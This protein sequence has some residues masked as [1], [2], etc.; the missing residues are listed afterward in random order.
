MIDNDDL[1]P[2]AE[3]ARRLA[4]TPHTVY[5]WIAA[6]RLPAIRFS[7]KVIRVRR[8]DLEAMSSDGGGVIRETRAAYEPGTEASEAELEESRQRMERLLSMIRE[9]RNRPR[10]PDSP[11][12]GSR[13]ALLRH[14]GTISHEDA[15]ELRQVIREAKTYSPD[16]EL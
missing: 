1:L 9:L 3:V 16:P 2:V 13:E 10:P 14:V 7:R 12:P 4:V 11:R 6:G 8:G 5:R 15:E